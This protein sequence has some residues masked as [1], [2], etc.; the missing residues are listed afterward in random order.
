MHV[1]RACGCARRA[2]A[3]AAHCAGARRLHHLQWPAAGGNTPGRPGPAIA[4]S[5][6]T[7]RAQRR[8]VRQACVHRHPA[9]KPS[10]FVATPIFYVNGDPHLG[11]LYSGILA[12]AIQRWEVVKGGD[13]DTVLFATGTD[14]HGLKVG[15]THVALV[16]KHAHARA[17]TARQRAAVLVAGS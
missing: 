16:P 5:P 9:P 8:H 15:A 7:G 17:H 10:T 6:A 13:A 4:T 3:L 14:E 11:H 2:E 1:L 12:D